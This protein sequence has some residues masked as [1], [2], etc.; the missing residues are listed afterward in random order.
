MEEPLVVATNEVAG[1]CSRL[2]VVVVAGNKVPMVPYSAL[3]IL[4]EAVEVEEAVL[5]KTAAVLLVAPSL[6]DLDLTFVSWEVV[7]AVEVLDEIVLFQD[8]QTHGLYHPFDPSFS[9]HLA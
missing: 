8:L 7:V 6:V 1:V 4:L 5:P 2:E 9:D 3:E